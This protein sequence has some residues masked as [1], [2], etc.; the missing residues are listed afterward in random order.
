MKQRSLGRT[1]L[2]VSEIGFG[3]GPTAGLMIRG[4]FDDRRNAVARALD[5]GINY[6]DT[7]PVYGDTISE[8]NLGAIL[9]S[10]D[11]KP[12]IATKIALTLRDLDDI[13]GAV[14]RSVG[15][16][17]ARLGV[18]HLALVH[19]HNR[20]GPERAEKPDIGSGALLTVDDVLGPNGVVAALK[21]LR[22]RGAIDFFGCCAFGGDTPA[23]ERLIDSDAFDVVLVHYSLLNPTAWLSDTSPDLRDYGGVGASA[24]AA[25][26]GSIA[27]RVLEGGMLTSSTARHALA[28]PPLGVEEIAL[29]E[30]T[31]MLASLSN[32]MNLG[33]IAIRYALSNEQ[34]TT[35]LVGFSD[36]A[37]I[38]QTIGWADKGP[39]PISMLS[40]IHEQQTAHFTRKTG[41]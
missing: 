21:S 32:A 39:L 6:F 5:L 1:G 30:R 7:A 4:T 27:L 3:C 35:V 29:A 15:A 16:S 2:G 24:A 12:I 37:Q 18:D 31:T 33:E 13:G 34:L 25:G 9:R 17:L 10:L 22:D 28:G 41:P 19:L 11:A 20:V 8:A 40:H 14:V 26:M 36:T 23:V 38:E